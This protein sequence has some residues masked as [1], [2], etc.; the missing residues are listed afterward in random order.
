MY[1]KKKIIFSVFVIFFNKNKK[2]NKTKMEETTTPIISKM[3]IINLNENDLEKLLQKKKK[4]F[5]HFNEIKKTI[6]R[7]DIESVLLLQKISE[8]FKNLIDHCTLNLKYELSETYN[9]IF[10]C[11]LSYYQNTISYLNEDDNDTDNDTNASTSS[12]SSSSSIGGNKKSTSSTHTLF[13]MYKG[14]VDSSDMNLINIDHF[15]LSSIES[16]ILLLRDSDAKELTE[17]L[18]TSDKWITIRD[19]QSPDQIEISFEKESILL[20]LTETIDDELLKYQSFT[21]EKYDLSLLKHD[22]DDDDGEDNK[23]NNSNGHESIPTESNKASLIYIRP[24]LLTYAFLRIDHLFELFGLGEKV[25]NLDF[26]QKLKLVIHKI[27]KGDLMSL[28]IVLDDLKF[29]KYQKH[30]EKMFEQK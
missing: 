12:S 16:L 30:I 29:G 11:L 27:L 6:T 1:K 13:N 24:L 8:R 26:N 25:T 20:R 28:G 2:K 17:V 23:N 14:I 15:I 18:T 22:D 19:N 3:E 7:D 5:A 9:D 21:L 10:V 4:S